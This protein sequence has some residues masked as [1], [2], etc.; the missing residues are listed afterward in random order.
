MS[1]YEEGGGSVT[2]RD[3]VRGGGAVGWAMMGVRSTFVTL[4]ARSELNTETLR[5][6]VTFLTELIFL[7]VKNAHV[8]EL[9]INW[10][11]CK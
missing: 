2:G 11:A 8:V 10:L 6:R 3:G 4:V 7:P 5:H 1:G 9:T